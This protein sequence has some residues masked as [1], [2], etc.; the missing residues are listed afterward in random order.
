MN[1][2]RGQGSGV[3]D[4]KRRIPSSWSPTLFTKFMKRMGYRAT[5][6]LFGAVSQIR[7]RAALRMAN[8]AQALSLDEHPLLE[9][10]RMKRPSYNRTP[11]LLDYS[12]WTENPWAVGRYPSG[13]KGKSGLVTL[14]L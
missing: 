7:N 12:M 5:G 2:T 4:Q 13:R 3:I 10:R 8:C 9:S 6:N 11:F 1:S 14:E